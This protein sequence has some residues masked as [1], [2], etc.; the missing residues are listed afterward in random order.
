MCQISFLNLALLGLPLSAV[1]GDFEGLSQRGAASSAFIASNDRP[2]SMIT[3]FMRVK[4]RFDGWS[5]C[6][7]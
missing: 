7:R 4:R 1:G 2:E 6:R 3:C 5:T